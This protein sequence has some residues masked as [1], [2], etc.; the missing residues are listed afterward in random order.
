MEHRPRPRRSE[1]RWLEP[2]HEPLQ[3]EMP[4]AGPSPAPLYVTR[5][6]PRTLS[7]TRLYC[8][9]AG[10]PRRRSCQT[11]LAEILDV[12]VRSFAPILPHLAEEVFQHVPY[13][14]GKEHLICSH[15]E[16]A[17][18]FSLPRVRAALPSTLSAGA[19]HLLVLLLS[20]HLCG[21]EGRGFRT[22]FRPPWNAFRNVEQPDI[23]AVGF[24]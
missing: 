6:P 15:N 2:E 10:D 18:W 20:L 13:V 9:S 22:A 4:P 19:G 5:P 21:A 14:K 11:A 1:G 12:M 8:E 17:A 7:S 24:S 16:K 23:T 3:G